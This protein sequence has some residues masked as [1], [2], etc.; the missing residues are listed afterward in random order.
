MG[1]LNMSQQKTEVTFEESFSD[2]EIVEYLQ[3]HPDFFDG[4]PS[5]LADM[6]VAHEPGGPAISLVERQIAVLRQ[7]GGE[8]ERQ[9]KELVAVAKLNDTL[10]ERIH[11]LSI[12]LMVASDI[13]ERVD[14]LET[15]LREEFRAERAA[16]VLFAP[17]IDDAVVNNGFLRVVDR[18]DAGLNPFA[19]FL[20]SARPRCGL[21]RDRQ[22]NFLF[23]ADAGE[24]NSAALVPLGSRADLGFLTIGSRDPDYFNPGKGVE[25]LARLGELVSVSLAGCNSPAEET[26]PRKNEL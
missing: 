17:L 21:I 9:L 24:I 3:R 19:S 8:L 13:T 14:L 12:R 23:A 20:K 5:L 25:F 26:G 10:M 2:E 11:G 18:D 4:Y 1:G 22:K 7:R 6:K 16:L 15:C